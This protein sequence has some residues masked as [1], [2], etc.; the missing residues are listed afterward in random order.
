VHLVLRLY[1]TPLSA[2]AA[3]IDPAR[4]PRIERLECRP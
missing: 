4:L 3:A 2:I 1:D